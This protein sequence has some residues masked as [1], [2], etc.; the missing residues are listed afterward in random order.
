MLLEYP[1]P[2]LFYD[3]G[4]LWKSKVWAQNLYYLEKILMICP[5]LYLENFR[6]SLYEIYPSRVTK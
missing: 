5:H 2:P 1:P 3:K 4:D 6:G